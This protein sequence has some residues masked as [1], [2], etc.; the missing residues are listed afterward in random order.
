MLKP[1]AT[2][3]VLWD[4]SLSREKSEHDREI[5]FLKTALKDATKIT[6]VVFRNVPEAPVV[7][8]SVDDLAKAL[9]DIVYDGGTNLAAALAAVPKGSDA[10]LFC[11]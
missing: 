6:L 4:A 2:P 5:E 9:A 10:Y 8:A 7:F 11:D 1:S 3:V